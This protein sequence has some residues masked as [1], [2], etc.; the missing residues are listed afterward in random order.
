MI[1]KKKGETGTVTL[2]FNNT[3]STYFEWRQQ[4]FTVE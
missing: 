2:K 4:Q 1:E 3:V